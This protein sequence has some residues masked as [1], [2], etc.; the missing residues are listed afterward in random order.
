MRCCTSGAIIASI[1]GT[2]LVRARR[3]V[4]VGAVCGLGVSELTVQPYK[5]LP[6]LPPKWGSMRRSSRRALPRPHGVAMTQGG[7]SEEPPP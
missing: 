6:G 2:S 7:G 1:A 4:I 3:T 5:L